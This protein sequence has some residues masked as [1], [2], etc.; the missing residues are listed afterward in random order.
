MGQTFLS[1]TSTPAQ[2]EEALTHFHQTITAPN[3]KIMDRLSRL[4]TDSPNLLGVILE[5]GRV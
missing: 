2:K 1:A 5:E 4:A 3:S